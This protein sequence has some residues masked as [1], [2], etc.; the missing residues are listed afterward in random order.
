MGSMGPPSMTAIQG[1]RY[2]APAPGPG[3]VVTITDDDVMRIAMKVKTIMISKI[4][5]MVKLKVNEATET[6]TD[7]IK[8]N[9]RTRTSN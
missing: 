6:M 7:D 5:E 1:M 8:K 9:Y 4:I 3:P 2:L